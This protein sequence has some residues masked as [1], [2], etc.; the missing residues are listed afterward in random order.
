MCCLFIKGHPRHPWPKDDAKPVEI[1]ENEEANGVGI[2]RQRQDAVG[3]GNRPLAT[4]CRIFQ[5]RMFDIL[6]L[7]LV[8]FGGRILGR[9]PLAE[10]PFTILFNSILR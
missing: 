10:Q 5:N 4:V 3:L 7:R 8:L 9:K 6:K 2:R 1:E